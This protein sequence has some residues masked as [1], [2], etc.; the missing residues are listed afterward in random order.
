MPLDPHPTSRRRIAVIGGGISGLGAAHLLAGTHEVTVIEAEPRLGGHARTIH[1][2]PT[3]QPVD[4]G[5]I[6]FNRANYPHLVRL[7]DELD[8]PVVKSTMS[9][10]ASI[11]GGRIEYG[12]KDFGTLFSQPR[13]AFDPRFL[14]MVRDI[15]RF[16]ARASRAASDPAMT[17]RDFLK[18][19]GTGNYFRDYYLL[20][21]SGAIWSTP[22]QGIMDFPARAMVRFFENHALL[23]YSGQHQWWTV[24]GGSV[25]YVRRLEASLRTR[26]VA[27]RAGTPVQAV[28]RTMTGPEVKMPGGGW[29]RFDEVIFATHSDDTLRLLT[30]PTRAEAA[31]LG[32]IRYQPNRVVL[33]SDP[34]VMPRRRRCWSSWN[35]AEA[36]EEP[37]EQIELTYWMN[38]LQPIPEEIPAFV[39]LNSRRA[40]DERLIHDECTLRHPVYDLGALA[41]Q[42]DM[43]RLNGRENTWFCG[44]WMGHGFHEDGL[45]SAVDVAQAIRGRSPANMAAAPAAAAGGRIVAAE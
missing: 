31:A 40:I 35:Y 7:F 6:V 23:T 1:V 26:G 41:A 16:N 38:S 44:A 36:Q 8:V 21:L 25:A 42:A 10:G 27:I 20:P 13:N 2:G 29:E 24:E 34:S 22:K 5:F 43:V 18:R 15:F 45:R 3:G 17:I 9:F 12:L 37:G 33:H 14:R 19:L 28:R 30:D 39:T 4:T 11:A 32:A